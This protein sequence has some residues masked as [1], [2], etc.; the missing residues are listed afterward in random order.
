MKLL[1]GREYVLNEGATDEINS[2]VIWETEYTVFALAVKCPQ[3]MMCFQTS[4]TAQCAI[5]VLVPAVT[6]R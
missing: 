3:N 2:S 4:T 6:K 5:P 1:L